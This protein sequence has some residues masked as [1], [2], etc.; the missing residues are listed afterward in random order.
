MPRQRPR[1]RRRRASSAAPTA[2]PAPQISEPLEST[3]HQRRLPTAGIVTAAGLGIW[4]GWAFTSA[5]GI[6]ESVVLWIGV[7]MAGLGGGRLLRRRIQS[8]RDHSR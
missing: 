3:Q 5:G 8:R 2:P 6:V 4:L 1:R 7:L